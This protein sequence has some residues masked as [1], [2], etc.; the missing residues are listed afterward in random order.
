MTKGEV[1][2]KY[3]VSMIRKDLNEEAD[4]GF[5]NFA[6][7]IAREFDEIFNDDDEWEDEV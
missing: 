2:E 7:C 3:G 1:L 5:E 6:K 4:E